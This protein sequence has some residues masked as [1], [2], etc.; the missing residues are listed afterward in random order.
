MRHMAAEDREL[1]WRFLPVVLGTTLGILGLILG[2]T[3]WD[4][5]GLPGWGM[6]FGA[7]LG[8]GAYAIHY[9]RNRGS[10]GDP[11]V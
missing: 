11:D 2:N 8:G 1:R 4:A 3:V 10:R 9:F 6:A 5:P 7:L